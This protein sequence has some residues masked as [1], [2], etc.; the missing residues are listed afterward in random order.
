MR[1]VAEKY[2][3]SVVVIIDE[4][5][6]IGNDNGTH[7]RQNL[8]AHLVKQLSEQHVPISL[9]FCGIGESLDNLFSSHLSAHRHFHPV[10]VERLSW[11]ARLEIIDNAA[12]HL[13]IEVDYTTKLRIAQISDGFPHY[14]HLICE[15]LFWLVYLTSSDGIVTG[16][17]FE[18]ALTRAAEELSPQIK[19]PYDK[20]TKKYS[21]AREPILWAAAD[22][23]QL[24][25]PSRDIWKS[26][27]RIMGEL[28]KQVKDDEGAKSKFNAHM[29]AMKK[30][31]QGAVL[32]GSRAGWYSYTE[33]LVRGYARLRALQ[34]NIVLGA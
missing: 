30:A 13:G 9:I 28:G 19:V 2:A 15:Q 16:D 4:F 14:V 26:Y 18:K 27:V 8:I 34:N 22:G 20:A 17:L 33:K 24:D 12:D 25:R 32:T 1:Y 7:E 6:Q 3:K 5:D 29:N 31:D 10:S 23:D 11:E 21:N